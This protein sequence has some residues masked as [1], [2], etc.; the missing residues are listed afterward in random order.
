MP[1]IIDLIVQKKAQSWI[2]F[3]DAHFIAFLD[4]KPLFP[5]HTLLSPKIH[6]QTLYEL[7]EAL[8]CSFFLLAQK[9]GKAVETGMK[10]EGSFLAINNTVSQSIQHLHL[11]L[12]PRNKGDG[13]KGFFWPRTGYRDDQHLV[14]TQKRIKDAL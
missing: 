14:E 13:L 12:V 5:G 7:P 10:A 2:V 4:T 9:L 11:H 1:C 3:E 8:I 6:I